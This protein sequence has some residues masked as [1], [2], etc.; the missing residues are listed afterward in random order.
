L[1]GNGDADNSRLAFGRAIASNVNEEKDGVVEQG[2][3]R[4]E[5]TARR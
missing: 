5:E 3:K 2:V 4:A 1:L